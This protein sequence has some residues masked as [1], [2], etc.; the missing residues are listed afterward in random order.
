MMLPAKNLGESMNQHSNKTRVWELNES[1]RDSVDAA[2]LVKSDLSASNYQ[3]P[4]IGNGGLNLLADPL[5]F[6]AMKPK[7]APYAASLEYCYWWNNNTARLRPFAIQAVYDG[8]GAATG[9]DR[10]FW[11]PAK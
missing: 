6:T 1:W 11:P 3:Y 10:V 2:A 8:G 9:G 4:I 5:G 7:D